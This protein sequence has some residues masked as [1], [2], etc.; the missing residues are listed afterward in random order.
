MADGSRH[1]VSTGVT[2][3]DDNNILTCRRQVFAVS[4]TGI[5]QALRV[6]RQEFHRLVDSAQVAALDRQVTRLS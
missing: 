3:A 4:Q 1:T 2:A 5:E 6:Q